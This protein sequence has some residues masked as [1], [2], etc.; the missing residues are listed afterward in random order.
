[1]FGFSILISSF[2]RQSLIF[3]ESIPY[4]ESRK[5]VLGTTSRSFCVSRLFPIL[6]KEPRYKGIEGSFGGG[7][8]DW[9]VKGFR[10]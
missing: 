4:E 8:L 10:W 7:W 1:M 6:T 2:N 3:R 9:G 5:R